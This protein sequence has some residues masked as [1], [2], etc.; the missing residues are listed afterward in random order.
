HE[1]LQQRERRMV[2]ENKPLL[3]DILRELWGFQVSCSPTG[4]SA[5]AT[6]RRRRLRASA[7]RCRSRTS[8]VAFSRSLVQGGE[9]PGELVAE[10]APRILRQQVRFAPGRDPRTS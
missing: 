1:L 9:V 10:A 7:S 8:F 3:T 6:P 5:C 2:R 4:S